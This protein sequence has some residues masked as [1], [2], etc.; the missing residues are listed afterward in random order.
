M[1][2]SAKNF[3]EILKQLRISEEMSQRKVAE[4]L[5][6]THQSYRAYE[7]GIGMPTME[8][9]LKLCEFFDVTPNELLGIK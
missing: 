1:M 4:A 6:I 8:N 3:P 5:G 9:F 2:Q 7:L